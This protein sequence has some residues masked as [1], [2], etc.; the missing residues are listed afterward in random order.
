VAP[1]TLTVS[2]GKQR[3][4]EGWTPKRKTST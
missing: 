1:G 4:I 3:T 2:A